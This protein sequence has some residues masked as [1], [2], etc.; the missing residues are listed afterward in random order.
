MLR[1]LP[2]DLGNDLHGVGVLGMGTLR[3]PLSADKFRIEKI[4]LR[5][6]PRLLLV[7]TLHLNLLVQLG[8][9]LS[10]GRVDSLVASAVPHSKLADRRL[11]SVDRGP[12]VCRSGL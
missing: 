10:R 5:W 11:H 12:V 9:D 4:S 8:R 7:L 6:P 1:L 3:L 2:L